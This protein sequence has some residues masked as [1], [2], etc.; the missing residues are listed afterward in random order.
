M[1]KYAL[2][3]VL[4]ILSAAAIAAQTPKD[5]FYFAQAARYA[6]D[7]WRDQV[8][9]EVKGGKITAAN[10]NRVGIA[11]GSRDAKSALPDWAALAAKAEQALVST[12]NTGTASVA[13]VS[14]PVEP[15]FTLAKTALASQPVAKGIYKKDGWFYGETAQVDAYHTINTALIAVVNGTIVDVLWNG[16]LNLRGVDPSKIITSSAGKYPMDSK[17]GAWHVQATKAAQAL[18][19]IQDPAKIAVNSD[20]K[21]DAISGV[22]ILVKEYLD[23]VNLALQGAK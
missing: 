16:K 15:F 5:G 4:V 19:K 12:Q 1:K 21:T 23:A 10:W 13:G 22:S 20:G 6:Q 7:G 11:A 9:L 14:I 8:V 3:A 18:V 17:Q 2:I